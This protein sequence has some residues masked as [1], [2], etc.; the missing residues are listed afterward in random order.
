MY[1]YKEEKL[2]IVKDRPQF[3][4]FFANHFV[5]AKITRCI[6]PDK[7]DHEQQ[8]MQPMELRMRS[9]VPRTTGNYIISTSKSTHDSSWNSNILISSILMGNNSY[10]I[11]KAKRLYNFG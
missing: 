10:F 5:T 6:L 4:S 8:Q 11:G 2:L 1:P 3:S 7:A 9:T